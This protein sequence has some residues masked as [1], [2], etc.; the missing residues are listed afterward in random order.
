MIRTRIRDLKDG[1]EPVQP[2]NS[3]G[4]VPTFVQDSVVKAKLNDEQ[5]RKFSHELVDYLLDNTDQNETDR[6]RD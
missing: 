4:L 1:T 2:P 5:K 3:L 6:R